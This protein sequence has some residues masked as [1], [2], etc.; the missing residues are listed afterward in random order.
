MT[1]MGAATPHAR[2]VI[3]AAGLGTRYG[4]LKQLD[5]VGPGGTAL[6]D[7]ALA[8][9]RRAGF[10]GGVVVVREEIA[11]AVEAHLTRTVAGR[12]PIELVLQRID[13]LPGG[14]SLPS[15]REKPWGPT[16]AVWSARHVVRGPFVVANA[17]DHYGAEAYR[18]LHSHLEGAADI[19][20]GG[21][22]RSDA[23]GDGPTPPWALAGYRLA[24]VLSPHGP[25]NRGICRL[26]GK[27]WL[28]DV[29]EGRELRWTE[30]GGIEGWTREGGAV[31][32][33]GDERVSTNLW[34]FS[35]DALD[36]FEGWIGRFL[37]ERGGDP[38]AECPLP[39]LIRMGLQRAECR[40]KTY[41]VDGDFFGMTRPEDRP[42]VVRRLAARGHPWEGL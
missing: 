21:G 30:V 17:D 41:A 42:E 4:S 3:L 24:S 25:V 35:S 18:V 5:P 7:F 39:D 19:P 20:G 29:V 37:D 1:T 2:L 27:G 9:A 11:E 13:D 12:F 23:P 6:L 14:R 10:G 38:D 31:R 8:D 33:T 26:D 15:G 16:H 32:L 28:E 34:A 36:R 40:V 22:E